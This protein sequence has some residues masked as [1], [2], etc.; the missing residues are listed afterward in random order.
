MW[1]RLLVGAAFGLTIGLVTL[2]QAT[3]ACGTFDET[4]LRL[5]S[6]ER[7]GVAQALPAERDYVL[8]S[9]WPEGRL[10]DPTTGQAVQV[11]NR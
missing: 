3:V 4:V 11:A 5:E 10:Y 2:A 8:L 1:I 7:D 9:L 6:V